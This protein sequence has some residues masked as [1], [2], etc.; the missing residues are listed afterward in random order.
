MEAD[1]PKN[2]KVELE[3]QRLDLELDRELEATF[4]ASDA[5]KITRRQ[6]DNPERGKHSKNARD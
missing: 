1:M 2:D 4:P 6:S 3:R 5:L